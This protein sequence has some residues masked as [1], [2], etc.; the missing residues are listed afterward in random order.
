MMMYLYN[1][2]LTLCKLKKNT[3][4]KLLEYFVHEVTART[5][6]DLLNIYNLIQPHFFTEKSGECL[7]IF[8]HFNPLEYLMAT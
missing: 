1:A 4:L 7:P 6:A 8:W 2:Q 5:A 3:Q